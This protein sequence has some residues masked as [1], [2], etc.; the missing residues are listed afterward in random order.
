M[1]N[2]ILSLPMPAQPLQQGLR[3]Q[4]LREP[5]PE[6]EPINEG[7]T[8]EN[9]R[10][11]IDPQDLLAFVRTVY[12]NASF[13]YFITAVIVLVVSSFHL[14]ILEVLPVPPYVWLM[15]ALAT[16]TIIIYIR[17]SS[18]LPIMVSWILVLGIVVFVTLFL[19][20]F[21]YRYNLAQLIL[22][23]LLAGLI[24][25]VMNMIGARCRKSCLPNAFAY[26]VIII[27]CIFCAVLMGFLAVFTQK[28][29]WFLYLTIITVILTMF[30]AVLQSEFIHGR[31]HYVP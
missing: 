7:F 22:S 4:V 30:A 27:T 12:I 8:I 17:T 16:L 2:K 6:E 18:R 14:R 9:T 25:F 10:T 24:V 23:A 19:I 28:M 15:V 31:M 11:G 26:T 13:L 29:R 20:C 21:T 3:L 5:E 1:S